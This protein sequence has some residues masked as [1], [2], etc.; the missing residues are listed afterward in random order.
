MSIEKKIQ[1][2]RSELNKH[3]RLYYVESNPEISDFQFDSM[4]KELEQLEKENPQFDD[5]NSPTKR[6]GSDISTEFKQGAHAF[7]M[8]S[9]SNTYSIEELREFDTRIAKLLESNSYSYV[10]ELKFDGSSISLTYENGTLARATTRGDGTKGDI[11]TQNIRTIRSIPLNLSA[12]YPSLFEARG[13]VLMP[14]SVFDNLNKNRIDNG[15]QLFA[16]P[17]N[18]SAG[19]LKLQKSSITAQRK[20]DAFIYGL[21]T[22]ENP[23]DS[24]YNNLMEAKRMGFKVSTYTQ[25]CENIK[26]VIDYIERIDK[27][28]H[29]L[30]YATDGVVIKVNKLAQQDRLG[31]TSKSPRWAVAYKFKA[32]QALTTLESVDFQVGRTGNITPVANLK[33]VQLAG[34]IVKRASLHNEDII[35]DLDL[36]YGDSV[37]IEKGGEIIPKVTSVELTQRP[38]NAIKVRFTENCPECGT[39]LRKDNGEA[40]HYCPNSSHCTP[41]LKGR[42]EHF[43]SRKAMDIQGIGN[44]LV[45]QLFESGIIHNSLDLYSIKKEDILKLERL[46]EKSSENLINGIADSKKIKFESLLYALGIRHV[47]ETTARDIAKH[48]KSL[49]A[50]SKA[51]KEELLEVKGVGN[52][53][54]QSVIDF[55][56]EEENNNLVER[57]KKLGLMSKIE[58]KDLLST[59]LERKTIVISGTFEN[60]SRDEIK[61]LI[62][63]N[64]GKNGN[65]ISKNTDFLLAGAGI[66]PSK[67]SKAKEFNITIIGESDFDSMIK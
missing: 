10:C 47:G 16:N 35:N 56:L 64:G 20:L 65:S 14:I 6:V 61:A 43:I 52:K 63:A 39:K 18:A 1:E 17:R 2:L 49:E 36:Y 32:E 55:F 45:N 11:V 54:A 5:E 23:T 34:T 31:F 44:E 60:Y 38:L 67:L 62:E 7:P 27:D 50:I 42:I 19:S 46:A 21:A 24:H 33:P 58:E 8:L 9:L 26:E 41:Q 28:R 40:Q 66:G 51:S 48:F 12:P 13:E 59:K 30:D 57:I 22:N 3:N 15:E 53:V 25:K 4:M 29:N 37:Y